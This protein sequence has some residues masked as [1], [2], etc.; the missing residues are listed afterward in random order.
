MTVVSW[1]VV[2]W[3]VVLSGAYPLARAWHANRATTLHQ[4][5]CWAAAAWAAWGLAFLAE[6]VWTGTVLEMIRY[7]ALCLTGCAGVTV[8]GAR[9][10]VVG[11]W[12]FVVIGLLACLFLPTVLVPRHLRDNL[13][14]TLFL[15]ATLAIGILNYLPTRLGPPALLLAVACGVELTNLAGS[16]RLAQSWEQPARLLL[17]LTPWLAY[18]RLSWRPV[19][20]AI[21]DRV[22]LDFRDRFGFV[23]AQRLRE[24]FNCSATNAGWSVVLRWQGLRLVRGSVMP[25]EAV[26]K[27]I[28]ATLCA[29]L[30]RFGPPDELE[31]T[32]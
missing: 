1:A 2:S 14:Q 16:V 26:Q 32:S 5:I 29:M 8:L 11:G 6:A 12:N 19:P 17:A 31:S 7:L 15:A 13:P 30:K 27:Q 23:W 3:L 18:E 10:P 28:V 22:W 25:D 21:F 20:P 4:A 24:Q 9:R